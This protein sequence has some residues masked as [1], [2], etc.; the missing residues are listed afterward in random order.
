MGL[1]NLPS[2][3]DCLK[4]LRASNSW[5]PQGLS[6]HVMGLLYLCFTMFFADL[7]VS[8][9]LYFFIAFETHKFPYSHITFLLD[10]EQLIFTPMDMAVCACTMQQNHRLAFMEK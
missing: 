7:H 8:C 5:N 9:L 3:A 10:V 1:T 6:R 4:N 2:C